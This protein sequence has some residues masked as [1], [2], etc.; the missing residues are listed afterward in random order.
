MKLHLPKFL[1]TAVI[2]A[3]CCT[4]IASAATANNTYTVGEGDSAITYKVTEYTG[5][6]NNNINPN[7]ITL[8][9]GY[10]LGFAMEDDSENKNYFSQN[11]FTYTGDIYISKGGAETGTK[12]GMVIND[13]YGEGW[14]YTFGGSVYGDGDIYKKSGP[15]NGITLKFTGNMSNYT[16]DILIEDANGNNKLIFDGA[17]TGTGTISSNGAISMTDTVI[18]TSSISTTNTLSIAGTTSITSALTLGVSTLQL[19]STINTDSDT[20]ALSISSGTAIK[21]ALE[22]IL[23]GKFTG[24]VTT[25]DNNVTG[26]A[27]GNGY[28]RTEDL[29]LFSDADKVTFNGD[30]NYTVAGTSFTNRRL[31]GITATFSNV[32]LIENDATYT[33]AVMG[34][35][36]LLSI[37]DGAT[38]TLQESLPTGVSEGIYIRNANAAINLSGKATVLN[39]SVIDSSA[40]RNVIIKGDGTYKVTTQTIATGVSLDT[41]WTGTVEYSGTGTDNALTTN[42]QNLGNENSTIALKGASGHIGTTSGGLDGYTLELVDNGDTKA[43]TIANGN[44]RDSEALAIAEGNSYLAAKVKGTGSIIHNLSNNTKNYTAFTFEGDVSGWTGSFSLSTKTLALRFGGDASLVK[45][46]IGKTGGTLNLK[47]G[48]TGKKTTFTNTVTV[49]SI[50]VDAGNTMSLGGTTTTASLTLGEGASI[51]FAGGTLVGT[52]SLTLAAANITVSELSS[53]F[54]AETLSA[55]LVTTSGEGN[56][57]TVNNVDSWS[58]STYEIDGKSYTTSLSVVDNS[59]KLNFTL[60]SLP[61]LDVYVTMQGTGYAEGKLTLAM[62]DANGN[63]INTVADNYNV[64]GLYGDAEWDAIRELISDGANPIAITLQGAEDFTIVGSGDTNEDPGVGAGNVSFYGKYY[65]EY[66]ANSNV[67]GS[68]NPNYIPEPASA[69]LGLAALMMLATRRRRKA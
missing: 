18:N 21:I 50:S 39:Q 62:V 44:T 1:F 58:G 2:A 6:G 25:A 10:I 45:A 8:D 56:T 4:R 38:L 55:T 31:T 27:E 49:D 67:A 15:S 20:A 54:N 17:K 26:H 41:T 5:G 30:C 68:Y 12:K 33:S 40:D 53:Y 66:N 57:L 46:S 35:A 63:R 36:S 59:L 13:G 60:D 14:T 24:T 19:G 64:I 34:S 3:V 47:V 51:D 22:D 29:L 42:L 28:L 32:Y 69:T 43:L 7:N 9:D 23:A 48:N 65:G 61:T 52:G 37:G 16:G 11:N